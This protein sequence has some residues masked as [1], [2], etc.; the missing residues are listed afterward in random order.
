MKIA[1]SSSDELIRVDL[2]LSQ[3]LREFSRT[4]I[5]KMIDNELV[6]VNGQLIKKN[7]I[8]SYGDIVEI[9]LE[10][11]INS[12]K[13]SL[14]GWQYPLDIIYKDKD[15]AIINKPRGIISH[16]AKGNYDKTVVNIILGDN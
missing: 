10:E 8:L 3:R 16:H 11:N 12:K 5:Q 14:K 6:K 2:F 9:N 7:S 13:L 1:V 4:T 15:F